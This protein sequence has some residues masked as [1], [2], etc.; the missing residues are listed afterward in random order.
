MNP[1]LIDLLESFVAAEVRFL[2]VGGYAVGF[3]G[4]VRATKDLDVWVA[5][6]AEN[7]PKV[8]EA[9]LAFGAPL[10][11]ARNRTPVRNASTSDRSFNAHRW[12]SFRGRVAISKDG[13]VWK[14]S[15]PRYRH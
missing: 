14:R 10:A 4:H 2:V 9:L 12:H 13:N 11:G 5:A 6:D 8:V 1:D 7:A 15:G 3:H